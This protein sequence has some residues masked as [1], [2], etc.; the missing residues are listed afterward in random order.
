MDG[1]YGAECPIDIWMA[2]DKSVVR[3]NKRFT[4]N[5]D[6]VPIEES[7]LWEIYSLLKSQFQVKDLQI[8]IY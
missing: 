4:A 2:R 5:G 3:A 8:P 1:A 7:E 6:P